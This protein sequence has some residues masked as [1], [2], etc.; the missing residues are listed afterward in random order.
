[1]RLWIPLITA[2][3]ILTASAQEVAPTVV[4]KEADALAKRRHKVE[5]LMMKRRERIVGGT[6]HE[7]SQST[8]LVK[9]LSLRQP[10]DPEKD[11]KNV[12]VDE[13]TGRPKGFRLFVLSF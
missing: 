1:M 7:L 11:L 2:L 12:S 10:N 4:S 5:Q 3:S 8:N 9:T 6:A 13:R